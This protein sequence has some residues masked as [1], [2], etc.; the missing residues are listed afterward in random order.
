VDWSIVYLVVQRAVAEIDL[1][2][3][4]QDF[5]VTEIVHSLFRV[6]LLRLCDLVDEH[7]TERERTALGQRRQC[8]RIDRLIRSVAG[9]SRD[10]IFP[11]DA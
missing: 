5:I 1:R 2:Y 9:T 8:T 7:P 11:N 6:W 4:G 10:G 3:L